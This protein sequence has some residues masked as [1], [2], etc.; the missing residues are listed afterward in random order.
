MESG[1]Q[2]QEIG[3]VHDS[4]GSGGGPEKIVTT[5]P[6]SDLEPGSVPA[7]A[8][9]RGPYADL[10]DHFRVADI[11]MLPTTALIHKLSRRAV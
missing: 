5:V 3:I 8:P 11:W 2:S 6:V 1:S 10:H 4:D 9:S 7:L